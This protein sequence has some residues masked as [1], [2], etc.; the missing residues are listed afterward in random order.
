MWEVISEKRSGVIAIQL[1]P[2]SSTMY[3]ASFGTGRYFSSQ[4]LQQLWPMV[5]WLSDVTY[6]T[7]FSLPSPPSKHGGVQRYLWGELR[8]AFALLLHRSGTGSKTRYMIVGGR[9]MR[10]PF[11]YKLMLIGFLILI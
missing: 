2:L 3:K 7:T 11:H 10:K 4:A 8:G 5:R 6:H 9:I 1:V